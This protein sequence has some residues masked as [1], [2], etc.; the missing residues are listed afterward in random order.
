[1]LLANNLKD[2]TAEEWGELISTFIPLLGILA[3]FI[4][5]PL[6]VFIYRKT[7][8]R[9]PKLK[10]LYADMYEKGHDVLSKQRRLGRFL[11]SCSSTLKLIRGVRTC[12]VC[13]KT[14]S[15]KRKVENS[16]G[17]YEEEWSLACP[18]CN[19]QLSHRDDEYVIERTPTKSEREKQYQEDFTALQGLIERYHPII[20]GGGDG[21]DDGNITINI[22]IR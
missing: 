8:Q 5:V 3:I 10:G 11:E 17:D 9:N 15:V 19:T 21:G 6:V 7:V 12:P 18:R 14:Y 4:V 16:Y 22:N 13:G 20:E 1:M 2:F